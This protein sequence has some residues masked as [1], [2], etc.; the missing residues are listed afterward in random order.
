MPSIAVLGTEGT[1]KTV[2]AACLVK[3][4]Q[5]AGNG[6]AFDPQSAVTQ[7][8]V[9]GVWRTLRGGDWP[10]ATPAGQL[11]VLEWILHLPELPPLPFRLIDPPGHDIRR[12]F[13]D[14]AHLAEVPSGLQALAHA[15][16]SADLILVLVNLADFLGDPDPNRRVGSELVVKFL[17]DQLA[18]RPAPPRVA[19]VFTQ[20]D[21]FPDVFRGEADAGAIVA[22]HLPLVYQAVLHNPFYM[23]GGLQ[24]FVVASVGQTTIV[25]D[26]NG[27]A[28]PVPAPKF[29]SDGLDAVLDWIRWA[30]APTPVSGL[31]KLQ[32]Q[33]LANCSEFK[34]DSETWKRW[35][36]PAFSLILFFGMTRGCASS[37]PNATSGSAG[38]TIFPVSP[39]PTIL[40][41]QARYVSVG[42]FDYDVEVTGT[43]K[44]EGAAGPVTVYAGLDCGQAHWEEHHTGS[45]G[46]NEIAEFQIRFTGYNNGKAKFAVGTNAESI[47]HPSLPVSE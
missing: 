47:R 11:S 39:R 21:R 30:A 28:R 44:N 43:V 13:S 37:K 41:S 33:W 38:R 15:V 45:L 24:P 7:K 26:Q 19:L 6:A 32:A 40:T 14:N 10:P 5:R 2:F 23:S 22:A 12:L 3:H 8:Y 29:R 36:I 25:V 34:F 4:V 17:L 20:A 9:E 35:L 18:R 1:G 27:K 42:I 31:E 16:H 46:R